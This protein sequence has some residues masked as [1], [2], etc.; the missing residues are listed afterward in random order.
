M[1]QIDGVTKRY[2][3]QRRSIDA[4]RDVRLDIEDGEKVVIQGP[5]GGGKSTL[6]SIL[7]GLDRPTAGR[8]V[9]D[10]ADLAQMSEG[11]LTQVRARAIGF[12][13]QSFNLIPTLTALENVETA[14]VPTHVRP[15]KR[16]DLA[17]QALASVGLVDRA[18]HLPSELSGGQQ[19]RVSIA[20]ALVKEPR[21]ILADEPSG[22]LDEDTRDEVIE[23]LDTLWLERGLTLVI[24]THDST[25]ARQAKRRLIIK[26][27]RLSDP[28]GAGAG[29]VPG[30]RL[31]S[32]Q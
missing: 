13:F 16:R 17:T 19:Q 2:E 11:K 1:Y 6:L 30:A 8:V 14:L 22:N 5:T 15:A 4:L 12:V 28:A 27:G 7:G 10:G 21:V 18:L 25:I 31:S 32:P 3:Q 20:R 29:R 24:V 26:N 9:L 23:L